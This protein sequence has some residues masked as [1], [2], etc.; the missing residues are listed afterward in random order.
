VITGGVH[1]TLLVGR[2]VPV[3]AP[4]LLLQALESAEVTHSDKG[5][6]G[7]K[8]TFRLERAGPGGVLDYGL[9]AGPLLRP[10]DRVV[11]SVTFGGRPRVL[12]DGI[13]TNRQLSPLEAA[14]RL[15][16]IG[17]DLTLMMDQEEK[18]AEHP[19]Q[20]ETVIALKIIGS[21]AQYG[22][23]PLVIPPFFLDPPLPTERIP[24][25]RGTDLQYLQD[26]AERYGYVF[27]VVP[28]PVPLAN[29]AY[30]G[31]PIREGIPQRALS[32]DLGP[33]TNVKRIEFQH[34]SLAPRFVAGRIQDRATNQATPVASV[35]ST[36][37]PL[38]AE[39]DWLVNRDRARRVQ[40][41]AC[42]LNAAQAYA[43]AQGITDA[44]TDQVVTADGE[45]DT[46]RYGELLEPRRLVGLRG[47]GFQ[48]DGLYYVRE[49]THR[50]GRGSY[51]QG[52]KLAR[53]GM[54]ATTPVVRV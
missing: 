17:E 18:T 31:P 8:L 2:A 24:V 19:A 16:L 44:S 26:M 40:L 12:M 13:I 1:L 3:P 27:Y 10:F 14:A 20:D 11:I 21:Y 7:F 23:V 46:I 37:V 39:P 5:R 49:V 48:H 47:A 42:G 22:L 38:S 25:Q 54:G 6:A 45:L 35:A 52:F 41:G 15:T 4:P 29:T 32:V 33:E 36:R 28:G 43:R 30:W 34:D 51:G 9:L 50:I 53:E